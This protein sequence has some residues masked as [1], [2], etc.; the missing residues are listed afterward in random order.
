MV[1][2]DKKGDKKKDKED[3]VTIQMYVGFDTESGD[4]V[5]LCCNKKE[6]SLMIEAIGEIVEDKDVSFEEIKIKKDVYEKYK[7]EQW[8]LLCYW[9]SS[10]LSVVDIFTKDEEDEYEK[11]E[12]KMREKIIK[13]LRESDI[14]FF[15][16]EENDNDVEKLT[17]EE[18]L[19]EHSY[20][21]PEYVTFHMDQIDATFL[22]KI[23]EL[24]ID[25]INKNLKEFGVFVDEESDQIKL[26]EEQGTKP[27][28]TKKAKR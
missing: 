28:S 12:E 24:E 26:I 14:D 6:K 21:I 4:T 10:D 8:R 20:N 1:K 16:E 19:A 22:K 2:R 11:A 13:E 9:D 15:G 23:T 17:D 18:L 7:N 27:K 25:E 3:Y 5:V